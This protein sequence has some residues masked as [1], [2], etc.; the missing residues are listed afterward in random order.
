MV[1]LLDLMDKSNNKNYNQTKKL[2][3]K[4]SNKREKNETPLC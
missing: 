1:P 2:I 4:K 3:A